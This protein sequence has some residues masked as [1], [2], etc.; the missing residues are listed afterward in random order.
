MIASEKQSM[1]SRNSFITYTMAFIRS[2]NTPTMT[3][4]ELLKAE[5]V[6]FAKIER[7]KA[8]MMQIFVK[9]L[10]GKTVIFKFSC[11]FTIGISKTQIWLKERIPPDQQRLIFAGKKV[12]R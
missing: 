9:T 8:S 3:L 2:R 1:S 12:G 10:T 7:V 6:L 5:N 11:R 4:S